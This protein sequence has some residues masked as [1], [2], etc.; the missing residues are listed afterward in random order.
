M[1][2]QKVVNRL[3]VQ[4]A[5]RQVVDTAPRGIMFVL[6]QCCAGHGIN[7]GFVDLYGIAVF[8]FRGNQKA[9]LFLAA[10]DISA[11][12]ALTAPLKSRARYAVFIFAH[13]NAVAVVA[14]RSLV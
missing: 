6:P 8:R 7:G 4:P 14:A 1:L 11:K 2:L 13:K 5:Q 3:M 9:I 10:R 12:A